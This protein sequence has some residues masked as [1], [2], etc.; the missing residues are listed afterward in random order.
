M[1]VD[2]LV[3]ERFSMEVLLS[4]ANCTGEVNCRSFK[5]LGQQG[6]ETVVGGPLVLET[7]ECKKGRGALEC[8]TFGMVTELNQSI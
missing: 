8:K 5:T 3:G 6:G 7:Y 2:M 4:Q 1:W